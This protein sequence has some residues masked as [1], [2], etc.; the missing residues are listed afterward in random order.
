[1]AVRDGDSEDMGQILQ[2]ASAITDSRLC[3]CNS[4]A[5]NTLET[6]NPSD[7]LQ[8]KVR[9]IANEDLMMAN[10]P[11]P[12]AGW[13]EVNIETRTCSMQRQVFKDKHRSR[14]PQRCQLVARSRP[15]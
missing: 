14:S 11:S 9:E 8:V 5:S 6:D 12:D 3:L 7:E 2:D 13:R 1:M 4:V 10:I 15:L